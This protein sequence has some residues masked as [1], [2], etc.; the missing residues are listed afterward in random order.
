MSNLTLAILLVLVA[1]SAAGACWALIRSRGPENRAR[2]LRERFGPEYDA[3]VQT[4]GRDR[5]H[6]LLEARV[7]RVERF[8]LRRLSPVETRTLAEAWRQIE[9]RFVDSPTIAA[10][11]ARDLVDRAA[12]ALGYPAA[13]PEQREADLSVHHASIVEH[14][15]AAR[16]LEADAPADDVAEGTEELRQ[17]LVHYRSVFD[18]LVE[19]KPRDT[20]EPSVDEARWRRRRASSPV[21]ARGAISTR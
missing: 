10:V 19:R 6:E 13:S 1:I 5:A 16:A 14:H 9:E 21:E 3:V 2:R 4:S 11:T 8:S 20:R 17:A 18:E 7:R 12:R 15:R